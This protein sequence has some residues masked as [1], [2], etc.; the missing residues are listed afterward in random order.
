MLFR[1][2]MTNKPFLLLSFAKTTRADIAYTGNC[3]CCTIDPNWLLNFELFLTSMLQS[4]LPYCCMPAWINVFLPLVECYH[5][6]IFAVA[7]LLK[8]PELMPNMVNCC[9]C[10]IN[11]HRLPELTPPTLLLAI[12]ASMLIDCYFWIKLNSSVSVNL[13]SHHCTVALPLTVASSATMTCC[14]SLPVVCCCRY[15]KP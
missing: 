8:P 11:D 10:T 3:Q 15:A 5:Y 9:C 2:Q 14:F 4:L 7:G 12:A 13:T 1:R 6:T